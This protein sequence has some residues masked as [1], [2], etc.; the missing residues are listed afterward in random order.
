MYETT[1]RNEEKAI[2]ALRALYE[3][4]GYAPYKMTKFEEY[5]L[6]VQNKDFLI[7]DS[8]ITFTDNG[9]LMALK[10]DVT[11]SIIKNVQNQSGLQ[12]LYY[13]ENV[14]R[15]S[16]GTG[17]YREIMQ[18]GLECIGAIDTYCTYEVLYLAAG[19]LDKIAQNWVLDISHLGILSAVLDDMAVS[20]GVRAQI[21]SCVSEKNTHEMAEI[22]S[23]AGVGQEKIVLLANLMNLHGVPAEVLPKLE[24]LLPIGLAE[25]A[26]SQL[27]MLSAAL[28][29]T[30]LI[31]N[32]RIDF[33]VINDM[34]YYNGIVFRGFIE[35][36]PTGIVSGGQYDKL[37][38]KMGRAQKAIGF[39]VYLDM[40]NRLEKGSRAY[41]VDTLLLY[42]DSSDFMALCRAVAQLTAAGDSVYA[43]KGEN[44]G[45]SCRK[46]VRL[47]EGGLVTDENNA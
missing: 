43:Y 9:K 41:D 2:F 22:C 30:D 27:K 39:A 17:S 26:L 15:V 8:V 5:D 11:L 19:S 13:N 3:K 4:Y 37:M 16:K 7:S 21:L 24:A 45:L 36:I 12:K 29:A 14:Y 42:D 18:V 1:L 47:T 25:E 31:K 10:P 6:Y 40:L 20:D 34:N 38:E 44:P 46:C 23:K 33:S 32:I 28:G 35:N